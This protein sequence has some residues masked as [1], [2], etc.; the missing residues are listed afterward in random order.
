MKA[1]KIVAIALSLMLVLGCA[2]ST[3]AAD[4]EYVVVNFKVK[5]VDENR[6]PVSGII[7]HLQ[8]NGSM[9]S[10]TSQTTTNE[11]GIAE[12]PVPPGSYYMQELG[13][14]DNGTVYNELYFTLGPLGEVKED[15]HHREN[16]DF[17]IEEEYGPY[18][19]AVIWPCYDYPESSYSMSVT[20][21]SSDFAGARV[22][23]LNS[24]GTIVKSWN[25][26]EKGE[27]VADLE[28]GSYTLR[29]VVEI[30]GYEM[31]QLSN[32][33]VGGAIITPVDPNTNVINPEDFSYYYDKFQKW[34]DNQ[35]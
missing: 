8:A 33:M 4:R 18:M 17:E 31:P 29:E 12:F 2:V 22:D 30:N 11:D 20:L 14:E 19:G 21:D 9:H 24:E 34:I 15:K 3:Y 5:V 27:L 32:I 13:Y 10:G 35:N 7:M 25:L 1:R 16:V 23:V 28:P 6:E 26:K